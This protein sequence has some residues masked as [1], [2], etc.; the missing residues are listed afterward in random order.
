MIFVK[1]KINLTILFVQCNI[2]QII[3]VASMQE[4]LDNLIYSLQN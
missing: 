2:N 1:S 4:K 3:F